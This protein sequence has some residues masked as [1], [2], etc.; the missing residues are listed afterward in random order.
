MN[1]EEGGN[2][3][4]LLGA[5]YILVPDRLNLHAGLQWLGLSTFEPTAGASLRLG[6]LQ[7]IYA[8][9]YNLTTGG[10]GQHRLGLEFAVRG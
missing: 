9:G 10:I 3:D 6:A 7:I 8:F 1:P 5:R 4:L 2:I